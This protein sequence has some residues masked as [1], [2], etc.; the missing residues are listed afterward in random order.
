M[1]EIGTTGTWRVTP[2]KEEAFVDAWSEFAAWASS[3]PGAGTLRLSRDHGDQGRFVSFGI[4]ESDEAVRAWKAA[5][6]FKERI[7]HVLQHVEDFEA[8]ELAVLATAES[9]S[10]TLT[11]LV[12]TS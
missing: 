12:P 6:E 5:P 2:S 11:A 1:S 8:T 3:M 9:G 10:A 4:W 7:A